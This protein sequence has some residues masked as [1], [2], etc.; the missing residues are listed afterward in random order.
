MNPK[1]C[2][3]VSF[4]ILTISFLFCCSPPE[5]DK[6]MEEAPK[7][8]RYL[9]DPAPDTDGLTKILVYYDMEGI[10]GQNDMR[11]LSFGNEEYDKAREWLT[12]DVNAVIDGLFAGGA[13]E[14]YVV[15]AHGSGNPD[16]DML[17]DRMDKRA[18]LVSKDES[19]DAYT[20]L[21]EKGVYDAV[22]VVCMHSKT[23]GRGF[24]AHTYTIGME[25]ILN[26]MSI[27][28]TEIIAY[29]WGR[30]DVPVIFASG[31]DKLQEQLEWMDW[32][33]YV[34]VKTA[35]GAGDA[36]LIPFEEV[37]QNMREAAK[38]AVENLP[39]SKATHLTLPIKA[40]LRTV[41]P[42][43]LDQLE[44]VPGIDY[45][46]QTVTFT[47]E[48]FQE[49]YE[50]ITALIGVATRGYV[51]LLG[52]VIDTHENASKIYTEYGE[53]IEST[54]VEVESGLWK[55]PTKPEKKATKRKY[56]GYR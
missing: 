34:K 8:G 20:A 26:E 43:R 15:D 45:N 52:D 16:P 27:N 13:D 53:K 33:E 18:Q 41:Y 42:A 40:Q 46:D 21:T 1:K 23:G 25:W 38:R 30:A 48:D 44:G 12:N 24:A 47:A 6:P 9:S 29:S 35:K 11:S 2:F 32:L 37:H 22:A 36:D 56:F 3:V 7:M 5:K 50:G 54:W 19:F 4:F 10:S 31:D 14:I 49:A 51:R 28:E 17:V 39:N 55:P